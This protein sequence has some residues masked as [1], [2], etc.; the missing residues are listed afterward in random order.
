MRVLPRASEHETMLRTQILLLV[1]VGVVGCIPVGGF[2]GEIDG[3]SVPAQLTGLYGHA[4]SDDTRFTQVVG[5]SFS[6]DCA[7]YAKWAD[8]RNEIM[9]DFNESVGDN[10]AV[11]DAVSDLEK[12]DTEAGV[13]D[14]WWS[15]TFSM[16]DDDDLEDGD[17]DA[18]GEDD[19][20][21]GLVIAHQTERA[22]YEDMLKKG[23]DPNA[24]SFMPID[25]KITI[26]DAVE[27][28][29]LRLT[30]DELELVD[31]E[32]FAED[33]EDAK[34][35]GAGKLTLSASHCADFSDAIEKALD[36]LS[37]E[38][39]PPAEGEGEGEDECSFASDC[40]NIGCLCDDGSTFGAPVNSTSC[41]DGSCEDAA[42]LCPS[43][44]E[45]LGFA[46]TGDVVDL[47]DPPEETPTGETGTCTDH[48]GT[49]DGCDCG[50]GTFDSDCATSAADICEF[51]NCISGAPQVDDNASCG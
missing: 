22:D 30:T 4:K 26:E 6:M 39:V 9:T 42:A 17:F 49:A 24:D 41:F 2:E 15:V 5:F 16:F 19:A 29:S 32:D 38:V 7:R 45:D 40:A 35:I 37:V 12:V 10:D 8:D 46:W 23:R 18:F 1:G 50:C 33:G 36:D 47:T 48:L 27:E 28:K 51:N 14:E 21:V 34:E 20:L 44:C 3:A 11:D 31:S 25:G 43:T 13:P